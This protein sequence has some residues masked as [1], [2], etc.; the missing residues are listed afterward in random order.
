MI[1]RLRDLELPLDE[2][3]EVLDADDPAIRLALLKTHRKRIEARTY[4]LQ[5]VLHQLRMLRRG[6]STG[7]VLFEISMRARPPSAFLDHVSGFVLYLFSALTLAL[8]VISAGLAVIYSIDWSALTPS[9]VALVLM[10]GLLYWTTTS[11][12]SSASDSSTSIG[13]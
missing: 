13:G 12:A 9:L 1:A 11:V 2:I 7:R 3:R 5:F 6:P 8:I 4:R 10:L